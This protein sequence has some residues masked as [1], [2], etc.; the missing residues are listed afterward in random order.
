MRHWGYVYTGRL[1]GGAFLI[2]IGILWL[3]QMLGIIE[4]NIWI[5]GPI[6]LI[7][8]GLALILHRK[9]DSW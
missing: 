9:W 4:P 3:L 2:I 7:I 1:L 6:L 5:I 8:G